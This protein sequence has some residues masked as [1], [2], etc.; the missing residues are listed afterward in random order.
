MGDGQSSGPVPGAERRNGFGALRLLFASLVIL[1]HAPQMVD[2]TDARE[3][4]RRLFGTVTFGAVAVD[5][6]FLISGYLITASFISDPRTYVWKRVLRIYPAFLVCFAL[7]LFVVAPLGGSDL[8]ALGVRDW[9][10]VAVRMVTL[11]R[12]PDYGAFSGMMLPVLNGSMWTIVYEFRCYI[13]AAVFGLLGLYRRRGLYLALTVAMVLANLIFS[14]RLGWNLA[15]LVK[16]VAGLIGELDRTVRLTSV[17]MCGAVFR[18]YGVRFRWPIAAACAIGLLAA[19]F[20]SRVAEIGVMTLGAYVLFWVAFNV[21]WRPL[22]TINAKDDISYGVY[23]YAWPAGMLI[24]RCWPSISVE[25]LVLTTLAVALA[26]GAISWFVIEKPALSLKRRLRPAAR[27]D[28][29][30]P[31]GELAPP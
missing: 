14:T 24:L 18:L 10:D 28:A 1:S 9:M 31:E 4:L 21:R 13:A 8:S 2:G 30:A 17:F 20:S 19:T 5:G 26:C 15:L 12:P 25:M 29:A 11:K 3:P 7:C 22:Q 23:L 27:I 6:F 16:P